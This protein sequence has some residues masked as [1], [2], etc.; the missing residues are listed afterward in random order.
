MRSDLQKPPS[1][2]GALYFAGLF[3]KIDVDKVVVG[4]IETTGER[5]R[6]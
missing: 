1:K 2:A 4:V 6:W 5:R 3:N